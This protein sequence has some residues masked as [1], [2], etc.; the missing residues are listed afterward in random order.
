M[1]H[2]TM[3]LR[4]RALGDGG[5]PDPTPPSPGAIAY[6]SASFTASSRGATTAAPPDPGWSFNGRSTPRFSKG[7]RADECLYFYS[8]RGHGG[9]LSQ[10]YDSPFVCDNETYETAEKFMVASK[11]RLMGDEGA[12]D[13]IM[14]TTKPEDAK[15]L[16]RRISP[17]DEALWRANRFDIVRRGSELKFA[18]NPKLR[19]LLLQ[20]GNVTLVEASPHD[21]IWGIGLSIADA[22]AGAQWRGT[23]L[24]GV[25][26]VE[27][28]DKLRAADSVADADEGTRDAEPSESKASD[29]AAGAGAVTHVVAP[30]TTRL[31]FGAGEGTDQAAIEVA[32]EASARSAATANT[33][34]ASANTVSDLET[35]TAGLEAARAEDDARRDRAAE[36]DAAAEQIRRHKIF[37]IG[38]KQRDARGGAALN[39][40]F[41]HTQAQTLVILLVCGAR[42]EGARCSLGCGLTGYELFEALLSQ[43]VSPP[44]EREGWTDCTGFPTLCVLARLVVLYI[45]CDTKS[46]ISARDTPEHSVF[47]MADTDGPGGDLTGPGLKLTP[48]MLKAQPHVVDKAMSIDS[49]VK[50]RL[51]LSSFVGLLVGA[52]FKKGLDATIAHL[53]SL[54]KARCDKYTVAKC[55]LLLVKVWNTTCGSAVQMRNNAGC[56]SDSPITEIEQLVGRDIEAFGWRE[57]LQW[58]SLASMPHLKQIEDRRDMLMDRRA[59]DRLAVARGGPVQRAGGGGDDAA[60]AGNFQ[61]LPAAPLGEAPPASSGLAFR[62]GK[63]GITVATNDLHMELVFRLPATTRDA[64]VGKNPV[65]AG[66]LQYCRICQTHG[67]VHGKAGGHKCNKA[68]SQLQD[69]T[70]RTNLH[71]PIPVGTVVSR[72]FLAMMACMYG[73]IH[74][75]PYYQ[76]AE[77]RQA[78]HNSFMRGQAAVKCGGGALGPPNMR[79]EHPVLPLERT[80]DG[81]L[82]RMMSANGMKPGDVYRSDERGL[83]EVVS[84]EVDAS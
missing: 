50:R 30:M 5:G 8:H 53:R 65:G 34:A 20:T 60:G 6:A 33:V 70:V 43:T 10:F 74:S 7:S 39:H 47:E 67:S 32:N 83:E 78:A 17:W 49:W 40:K 77:D 24:L 18:Q 66:G 26:L 2:L 27:V 52:T 19:E 23:N 61:A 48:N 36:R 82:G 14:A 44:A 38:S 56:D 55:D 22:E 57:S 72:E 42:E 41:S 76:T 3:R 54:R 73:G 31:K 68:N 13:R 81:G 64:L 46:G 69:G 75:G 28:C 63:H 25:A 51:V 9:Y 71:D 11:A 29:V 59:L 58:S 4:Q 80:A 79:D 37:E 16:G 84:D 12:V 62:A 21:K 1:E 35:R 15:E 45:S